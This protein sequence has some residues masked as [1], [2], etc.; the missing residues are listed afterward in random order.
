[1]YRTITSLFPC[2]WQ[3]HVMQ[4]TVLRRPFCL[5]VCLAVCQR[6]A[7]WQNERNLRRHSYTAWQNIHLSFLARI[8]V[9]RGRP[10]LPKIWGQTDPARAKTPIF[11]RYS[12]VVIPS[13]K[14]SI[15]T[16]RKSTTRLHMSLRWT[17]YVTPK[18]SKGFNNAKPCK[19]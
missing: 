17:S 6:R 16:N 14:S 19:N 10:L 3:L 15:N 12:L 13:E 18:P 8:I 2:N 7:L 9:V 4:R 5:S 11:N 1:M